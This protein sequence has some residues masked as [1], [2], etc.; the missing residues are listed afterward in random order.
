ME[1]DCEFYLPGL[2]GTKSLAVEAQ[3]TYLGLGMV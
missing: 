3:Q 1:E 2:T